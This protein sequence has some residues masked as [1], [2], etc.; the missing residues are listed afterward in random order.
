MRKIDYAQIA[1]IVIMGVCLFKSWSQQRCN[2]PFKTPSTPIE[3]RTAEIRILSPREL[4]NFLNSK[5]HSRYKCKVDGKI[6]QE[7][8]RAWN[9]YICDRYAKKEFDIL[10]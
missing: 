6:G 1:L 9:N 3:A 8:I 7:T 4:Q 2:K 10:Q 5:G